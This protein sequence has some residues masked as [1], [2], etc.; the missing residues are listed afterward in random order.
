MSYPQNIPTAQEVVLTTN[1]HNYLS[2]ITFLTGEVEDSIEMLRQ[3]NAQLFGETPGKQGG[4]SSIAKPLNP[5]L[6]GRVYEELS[7]LQNRVEELRKEIK[8][9][10]EI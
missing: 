10:L 8:V 6:N 2:Q 9:I 4:E 5:A 1:F 7:T 3:K